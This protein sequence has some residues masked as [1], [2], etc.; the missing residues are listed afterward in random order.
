MGL[1]SLAA[2]QILGVLTTPCNDLRQHGTAKSHRLTTG[3][4][5]HKIESLIRLVEHSDPIE[6][7][8]TDQH[9]GFGDSRLWTSRH[10]VALRSFQIDIR[11]DEL[12]NGTED[13]LQVII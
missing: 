2:P 5:I 11:T 9:C 10:G 4:P 3:I 1:R 12:L 8:P 6:R 13:S 7:K